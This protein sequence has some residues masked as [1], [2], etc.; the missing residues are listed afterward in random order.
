MTDT[1]LRTSAEIGELAKALA[2]AQGA[3][4]VAAHDRENPHFRSHYATLAS[5]YAA[6][7]PAL[8]AHGLAVVQAMSD[9]ADKRLVL[10]T[11][12][13][14]QSGQWMESTVS[15][16]PD[17][18]GPQA[19]GSAATY[20]RRYAL[21]ALVGVATGEDDDG[22]AAERAPEPAPAKPKRQTKA[23]REAADTTRREGHDP[24]W[25]A[26]RA[27]F[28]AAC[29]EAGPPYDVVAAWCEAHGR[30][31]PSAMPQDRRDKL[32]EWLTNPDHVTEIIEWSARSTS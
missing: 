7:R 12:L 21:V 25:A 3:I 20:L 28:A 18:P 2:A 19:L 17:K 1:P 14:H 15:V 10:T 23:E 30:P 5:I 26:D 29:A 11:R 9:G 4:T 16:A 6:C 24:S 22:E 8:A 13:L 31:R 32:R 27:R